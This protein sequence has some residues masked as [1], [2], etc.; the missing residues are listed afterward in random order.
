MTTIS[1]LISSFCC[2]NLNFLI[3]FFF[4]ISS[5]NIFNFYFLFKSTINQNIVFYIIFPSCWISFV[6]LF[7]SYVSRWNCFA[8]KSAFS[9]VVFVCGLYGVIF[10]ERSYQLSCQVVPP[11]LINFSFFILYFL[12]SIYNLPLFEFLLYFF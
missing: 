3:R 9:K 7:C 2:I 4:P 12:P 6:L 10:L 8:H 11:R 1:S 5:F